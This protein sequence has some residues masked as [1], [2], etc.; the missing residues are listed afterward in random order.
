MLWSFFQSESILN[1]W[2]WFNCVR[3]NSK[4]TPWKAKMLKK[5]APSSPGNWSMSAHY[6]SKFI[7]NSFIFCVSPAKFLRCLAAN[8]DFSTWSCDFSCVLFGF[9]W[10]RIWNGWLLSL[11]FSH[12]HMISQHLTYG[13]R[14]YHIIRRMSSKCAS[15][16]LPCIIANLFYFIMNSFNKTSK[17]IP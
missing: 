15:Y 8:V 11:T 3:G 5:P 1:H 7:L 13:H 14:S 2:N 16:H 12:D 9:N 6:K 17:Y 10:V 4:N